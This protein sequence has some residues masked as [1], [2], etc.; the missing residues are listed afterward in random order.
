M[1]INI[2][3]KTNCMLKLKFECLTAETKANNCFM[4]SF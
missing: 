4:D 1:F 2:N 3:I